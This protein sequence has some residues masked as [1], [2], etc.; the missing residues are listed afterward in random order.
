MLKAPQQLNFREQQLQRRPTRISPPSYTTHLNTLQQFAR[1]NNKLNNSSSSFLNE[2]CKINTNGVV[3]QKLE[4]SSS[5][6]TKSRLK[7]PNV[8]V[9]SS[10]TSYQDYSNSKIENQNKNINRN[11]ATK[12]LPSINSTVAVKARPTS[13]AL[14][15]NGLNVRDIN[16]DNVDN[17][18]VPK[19]N[20]YNTKNTIQS[21]KKSSLAYVKK[22]RNSSST[23]LATTLNPKIS[24]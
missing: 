6:A 23:S 17:S 16:S 21:A 7:Q 8:V 18:A 5:A 15:S 11:Q 2:T 14:K 13:L 10:M 3:G 22:I 19:L 4:S 12:C 1:N 20:T 24:K 9:A